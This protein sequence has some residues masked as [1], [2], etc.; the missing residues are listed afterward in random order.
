MVLSIC[1]GSS[2]DMVA[3]SAWSRSIE[4]SRSAGSRPP[5]AAVSCFRFL[6]VWARCHCAEAHSASVTSR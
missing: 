5:S 6:T 3:R 4:A 1:G 2:I